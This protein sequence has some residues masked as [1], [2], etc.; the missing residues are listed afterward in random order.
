MFCCFPLVFAVA[1]EV[2]DLWHFLLG[3][4]LNV[5]IIMYVMAR[6]AVVSVLAH[7][8]LMKLRFLCSCILEKQKWSKQQYPLQPMGFVANYCLRLG[9]QALLVV[10]SRR[11]AL[12]PIGAVEVLGAFDLA[13]GPHV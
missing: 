6:T 3:I 11:E 1:L 5:L 4:Q 2:R 10:L 7:D 13:G 12:T 9:L 8:C